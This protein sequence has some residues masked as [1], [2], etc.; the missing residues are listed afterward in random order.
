[1]RKKS[2][3]FKVAIIDDHELFAKMLKTW[4]EQSNKSA[5]VVGILA[6]TEEYLKKMKRVAA[7]YILI[8]IESPDEHRY[9]TVK[10]L[11]Q[12]NPELNVVVMTLFNEGENVKKMLDA[13]VKGFITK[14]VKLDDFYIA[15]NKIFEGGE[16]ISSSAAVKYAKYEMSKKRN[17]GTRTK[18]AQPQHNLTKRETEIVRL[19]IRGKSD[20]EIADLLHLSI[21]T[22]HAHKR[23]IRAKLN[24][25]K[26]T[27]I[28][29]IAIRLNI[30]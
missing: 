8:G 13:G 4:V 22:I 9:E 29:N 19:I 28:V 17:S 20:H 3:L 21:R 14:D 12:Q 25:K 2:P 27:E 24:V 5:K 1:M 7:D 26:T 6:S 23:N 30:G 16:Y 10:N 11:L 15:L 18:T